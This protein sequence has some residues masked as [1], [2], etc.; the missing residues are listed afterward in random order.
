MLVCLVQHGNMEVAPWHCFLMCHDYSMLY[1]NTV[2]DSIDKA[3]NVSQ[4]HA[5]D[6]M[7]TDSP[8]HSVYQ[9]TA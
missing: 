4:A 1:L 6:I 5:Q 8:S 2:T 3:C 9:N 7:Q